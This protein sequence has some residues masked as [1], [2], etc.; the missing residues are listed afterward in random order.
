MESSHTH[1][2]IGSLV[3]FIFRLLSLELKKWECI[4]IL[5]SNLYQYTD[6]FKIHTICVVIV[7]FSRYICPHVQ[8]LYPRIHKSPSRLNLSQFQIHSG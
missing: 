7:E 1:Y 4:Y 5:C 8:I 6:I 3:S 2:E